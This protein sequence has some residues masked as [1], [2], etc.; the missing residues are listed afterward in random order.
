MEHVDGTDKHVA[1]F[2]HAARSPECHACGR[3]RA[4]NSHV[5]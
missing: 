1:R 3:M 2:E 5:T 4:C